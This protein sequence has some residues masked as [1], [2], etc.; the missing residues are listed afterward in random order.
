MIK[1]S[2][3]TV[4][5][6]C[7]FAQRGETGNG[8]RELHVP[9]SMKSLFIFAILLLLVSNQLPAEATA[10]VAKPKIAVFSGPRATIQSS[11]ALV[12][13]NKARQKYGLQTLK[14]ADGTDLKY[15]HLAPQ[16]LAAPVEVLIEMY[17]AH[18]MEKDAAEL[19]APADG[20]VDENGK[21]H[22]QQQSPTDKPV[23]KA[24]LSPEDGLYLL[25][26]MARQA[27][28]AAWEQ[29]C[30]SRGAPESFCRQPFYADASRI[31]EEI[32]RGIVGVNSQGLSN[33]LSSKADFDFYRAVPSA[34][35]KKGLPASERS[36]I[37]DGDIPPEVLGED[38]FVYKPFHLANF[39]RYHDLARASNVVKM[40][41]DSGQYSGGIWFE[42]S[43]SIEETI[44]WLNITT[45]TYLP[46]VGVAAQRSHRAL[47]SDGPRNI[48][49][50]VNY[51][52][53]GQWAD[54]EGKDQLGAVLIEA[55]KIFASRQ[56][57]KSDA[58]PGGYIATGDH[59]GVLGTIGAP[60]PVVVY[61]TP[62]TRH[63][64]KSQVNLRQLPVSVDGVL[65]KQGALQT[66]AVVIKDE[67]GFLI[68]ESLP[69]I[70]IVK[71]AHYS[72]NSATASA[73]AAVDIM[74]SISANLKSNP[75][76]GFVAEGESPYGN[77]TQE[78]TRALEIAAYSGM[79]TVSVGRGN[80]GGLTATRPYN[81]FIE[82][83]NLTASKAR[84]LLMASMMKFG[85]LP[86]AKDP[87]NASVKEKTAVQEAIAKYQDVFDSH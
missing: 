18:P 74:A 59:G 36:D 45:Q 9:A 33:A 32:D 73:D 2:E 49:D 67:N 44:Y 22:E 46:I 39:T 87:G 37:G 52:L 64:W 65:K 83:N 14:N 19:Y 17:S 69:R 26:Y 47:S 50:S 61:F 7:W 31:F 23:Y 63:T 29:D 58:R 35:Y 86:V 41:L 55:E 13:S 8:S 27:N 12:T 5:V 30:V 3:I 54:A 81:L 25:P 24:V 62:R 6:L 15:D 78:Q 42:A 57:Q 51:I 53:S 66:P 77:M 10:E 11:Q 16:R 76:A 43:P 70:S 38:F 82:G 1:T 4:S 75:L 79:P 71:I 28:G 84:L 80:A 34:G 20:Y 56:V 68:G 85:S 48:V 72:Q 40:A 21:F 60:G